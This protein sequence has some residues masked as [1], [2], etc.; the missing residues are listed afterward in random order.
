[1]ALQ[2]EQ[3]SMGGGL[4]G[5]LLASKERDR[6]SGGK[7]SPPLGTCRSNRNI[8]EMQLIPTATKNAAQG[9]FHAADT[10]RDASLSQRTHQTELAC[11]PPRE[12]HTGD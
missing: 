10:Q 12:I 11:E 7:F 8:G 1:M 9:E 3:L 4:S 5:E 6:D 2:E